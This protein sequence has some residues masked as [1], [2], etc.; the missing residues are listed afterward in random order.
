VEIA[1][2]LGGRVIAAA[3]SADK[4][5][6]CRTH[7]AD[8]LIDY[9]GGALR[10][11]LRELAPNGVDVV[12]DPVGGAY[13][14]AAMRGLA[15]RGRYLVVGFA[16]GE[17]PRMPLNLVLLKGAAVLGVALGECWVREPATFR[18]I[19]AGLAGLVADGRVR[20]HVTARY[21]LERAGEALRAM[22]DRKIVGKVVIVP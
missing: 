16:A 4:L 7:G 12:Y 19:E 11:R 2:A 17:I 15:W 14:E 3:S 9:S 10:E 6:L 8:Q 1:K 20:A 5:E 22:L 21:P 13:A 18:Q